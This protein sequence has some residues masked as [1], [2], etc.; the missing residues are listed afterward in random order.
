MLR[1][2]VE[3][4][5]AVA[6]LLGVVWACFWWIERRRLGA[7]RA[8]LPPPPPGPPLAGTD[9]PLPAQLEPYRVQLERLL[10][11]AVRLEP[12][13]SDAELAVAQ[14]GGEPHLPGGVAWPTAPDRPLSFVAELDLEALHRGLPQA[15]TG[16]PPEGLL[17]LF[18]D[19]SAM[20][21]GLDPADRQ[22]FA[23][24]HLPAGAPPR[25]APPGAMPFPARR[26]TSRSVNV[27][28]VTRP[29]GLP[30]A[31]RA[32][33]E[34][35][36]EHALALPGAAD[37]RVGGLAA[38]I[39]EDGRE[40]AALAAA[41]FAVESPRQL[42]AA[43]R[44]ADVHPTDWRRL[45]QLDTDPACRFEWGDSGRLYLLG[46]DEDVRARRFDRTWLLLQC[47]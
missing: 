39:Q 28:P 27:L 38:W 41:G 31:D 35:Y 24:L 46:R 23:V 44:S 2:A 43:R 11:P 6:V 47:Y 40:Q 5:A 45:L 37:H 21:W 10:E 1:F 25:A 32:A 26:M 9:V 15:T 13:G 34:C 22:R 14:L 17:A 19:A 18:Y 29:P 36:L 7:I 12:L 16:L 3:V 33:A 8:S 30:L 42:A 4:S 20:A